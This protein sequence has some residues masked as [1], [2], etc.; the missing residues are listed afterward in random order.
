MIAATNGI[1]RGQALSL[2]IIAFF[3]IVGYDH[4]L[5]QVQF[6]PVCPSWLLRWR[7]LLVLRPPALLANVMREFSFPMSSF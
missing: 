6:E 5:G 2:D 4:R 1:K 7:L 3:C